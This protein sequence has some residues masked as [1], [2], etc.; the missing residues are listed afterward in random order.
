MVLLLEIFGIIAS[1][2]IYA[3]VVHKDTRER[4]ES[5]KNETNKTKLCKHCKTEIPAGAKICP[6]CRKKQ[7]GALKWI[8]LIVVSLFVIGAIAGGGD[9]NSD[10]VAKK[11]DSSSSDASTSNSEEAAVTA[12]ATE[13]YEVDLAS[14]NYTAGKDIPVGTYNI[15]AT[16]GSGNVSSSNMYS[17]G[18]NEIMAYPAEDGYSVDAFNGLKMED[19][20]TL[21]LSG[22]VTLHLIA[23]DAEVSSVVGRTVADA[24]PIDLG[25]GNYTAG[26]DFPA[27]TYN[28]VST[29]GSGNVSSDNM[30]SGGLNE[31]MANP[32]ESGYSISQYNNAVFEEGTVLTVS[33]T[34]VQLVPVGE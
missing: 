22:G 31:I 11:S 16:G 21:T 30:Y 19:G 14:G 25:A 17:G 1:A 32:A 8:I 20:V 5:M 4:V 3:L 27:G 33:G 26:T 6:N 9:D 2:F 28:V 24:T 10:T 13:H 7:G 23:E 15:T 18:L 12:P 29:G 34:S